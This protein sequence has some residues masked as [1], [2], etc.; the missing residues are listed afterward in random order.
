MSNKFRT[1][2][3]PD[4]RDLLEVAPDAMVVVDQAGVIVLAN[5]QA[6]ALFGYRQQEVLGHHVEVLIPQRF[7]ERHRGHRFD[8][9][10]EPRV[11]P[12][13]AKLQL[14]ALRKNGTEFPVEIS[15]SPVETAEGMVVVNAIRD[16]SERKM[17]EES[18]LRLAAI[19]E[20]SAD[21]IISKTLDGV[22]VSWNK[23]AQQIYGYTE[24]EAV[25]KPI[26]I[27]VPLELREEE[28]KILARLRTGERIE[29]YETLRVTKAGRTVNISLSLSPIKDSTATVLGICSISHD[30]T[31]RKL[32]DEAL[33]ASEARLRL[34]QQA[35]RIGTF[36][37]NI[38]TGVNTWTRE[39]EAMYGLAPGGF[40]GTQTAFENLVHPDDRTRVIELNNWALKTGQPT[41]GEWRVVWADGSMHWI[42]GRWQ[43]FMNDSGEPSRMVGINIDMTERRRAEDALRGSEQR[44][45][46]LFE[47]NV[48][49]VAIANL[50]GFLLECN[51]GWAHI[52]GYESREE[53]P[54]RHASEFYFNPAERKQLVDE[55][56]EKQV[57]FSRELQLRRKDG[58]PVWVL[59]NAAVHSGHDRPIVQCTMIDISEW[60]RAE[61]TLAEMTRKLIQAQEQE[62]ARIA[63]ELHDDINQRL[64]MVAVQLGQLQDDP[65]KV[66]SRVQELQRQTIQISN[67]VQALSHDLHSSQL[68]YLGAVAGMRSWCKEFGERHGMQID[69]RQDVRSTL[70]QE[71]VLSLFRV[72]QEAL[73]NA[74]KHSGVK[75]IEV[76]LQEGSGEIHLIIRDAGRGF[77]IDT[78]R[79]GTGL[80]LVSMRERI[81]L[82]NGTIDIQ[83]KLLGG[84]T[85]RARVPFSL[86]HVPRQLVV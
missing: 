56:F 35:A 57:L 32:A 39:L 62:R 44:Y 67:D 80:G 26:T 23:G 84:T 29:H 16:V 73:H 5:S 74:A 82:V 12:M 50:D 14:F 68:E 10:A 71:I 69:F 53:L 18:Q 83:S 30:I 64:A 63:R 55:L 9:F 75:Q 59:F 41:T 85:I 40:E 37:W 45:R 33:R 72:L 4:L 79:Q 49:G 46:L 81:R 25:G 3:E 86:Q 48:A 65:S 70:P 78:A 36:E 77:D 66:R 60:K 1:T 38:Q 8:F 7:R 20:S 11:R 58:T 27:L 43:V 28:N 13:G 22:I 51:D 19:V 47:R 2:E 76:Q 52:L 42:A 61:E 34:A 15:L 21:A 6:E 17:A 31:E 24:A 54:G